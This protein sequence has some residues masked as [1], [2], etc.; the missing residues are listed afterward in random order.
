MMQGISYIRQKE[1]RV[2]CI[3]DRMRSNCLL[4]HVIEGNIEERIEMIG[5]RGRRRKQLVDGLKETSVCWKLK[6]GALDRTLM[7][8]RFER[9]CGP[10][11][12]QTTKLMKVK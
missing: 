1:E 9:D 3:G 12:R 7:G 2:I 6:E 4:K 10:V 8:T 5:R 11:V